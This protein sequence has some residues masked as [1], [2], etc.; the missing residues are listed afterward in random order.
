MFFIES[1]G[2]FTFHYNKIGEQSE[3]YSIVRS[4]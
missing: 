1:D 4:S 3:K 2:F